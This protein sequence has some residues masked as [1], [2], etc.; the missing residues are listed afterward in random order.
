MAAPPSTVTMVDEQGASHEVPSADVRDAYMSGNLTFKEGAPVPVERGGKV[1]IVSGEE[2]A[3]RFET[4][5]T[6][7]GS[8]FRAAQKQAQEER[9]SGIGPTAAAAGIGLAKGLT[10]GAAPAIA[11]GAA[12]AFGGEEAAAA[13]REYLQ[14]SEEEHPY[15]Q[16]AFE[17]GGMGL[18]ALATGGGSVAARGAAA[19]AGRL[20]A[21]GLAREAVALAGA[22]TRGIAALG[23]AAGGA[24]ERGVLALGAPK[25]AANIA[26]MAA[27]GAAEM[28][29]YSVGEAVGRAATHDQELTAEQLV[30]AAG[31]GFLGGAVFGGALGG[32]GAIAGKALSGTGKLATSAAER[33]GALQAHLSERGMVG[34]FADEM[35]IR[36]LGGG[37]A[38]MR[39]Y[40]GLRPGI[41]AEVPRIILEEVPTIGGKA[42]ARQSKEEIFATLSKIREETS[43]AVTKPLHELDA[44]GARPST[45]S[46][47]DR[48]TTEILKPL[49]ETPFHEAEAGIVQSALKS[50]TDKAGDA[51]FSEL[52]AMRRRLDKSIN[53]RA[54]GEGDPKNRAMAD[55]RRIIEDQ[56][57]A[58]VEKHGAPLGAEYAARYT[59]AKEKY[60]AANWA[61]KAAQE[62]SLREATNRI[63]GMTELVSGAAGAAT[64]LASGNPAGLLMPIVAH[65]G[66]TRG[67]QFAAD[68][69]NRAVSSDMVKAITT[70]WNNK[71]GAA[72]SGYIG[73]PSKLATVPRGGLYSAVARAA[74]GPSKEDKRDER[75]AFER[76]REAIASWTPQRAEAATAGLKADASLRLATIAQGNK[77]VS[78]LASKMPAAPPST[79]PLQPK[80]N[81]ARPP[82]A[83]EIGKWNRYYRAVEDPLSVLDDLHRGRVTTEGVEALKAVYPRLYM[84]LQ[85][86]AIQEIG[87]SPKRLTY[88]QQ[89]QLGNLLGIAATPLASPEV[90]KMVQASYAAPGPSPQPTKPK[91]QTAPGQAGKT[92]QSPT[93][94]LAAGEQ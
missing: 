40:R 76:R 14:G 64:T 9:F 19:G 13:T 79:D 80:L 20:G 27:R 90:V 77:A 54:V 15:V 39:E 71:A 92:L 62:G 43:R 72:I 41:Q 66:R 35:S 33:S 23:E 5:F 4:T 2:A 68:I 37:K 45:K 59:R 44:I 87:E 46:I 22:P 94:A 61:A 55:F 49:A 84:L 48:T 12:R 86:Q 67:A 88:Q 73:V 75:Q 81:Q 36:S 89:L 85:E 50:F 17:L 30:A 24:A 82:S 52:H 91:M 26:S 93:Q 28:P 7:K 25:A 63:Q 74:G 8:T 21:R 60:Q 38:L 70:G 34:T 65:Y 58:D 53:W 56:I 78:F 32:L 69:A 10:F 18:G 29:F 16:G 57:E 42:L 47:V 6:T 3:H 83:E 11:T 31:H 51:T 1:E